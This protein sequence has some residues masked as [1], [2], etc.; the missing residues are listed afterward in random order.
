MKNALEWERVQGKASK[1]I[2]GMERLPFEEKLK[3]LDSSAARGH[4]RG[5]GCDG[6]RRIGKLTS[7]ANVKLL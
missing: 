4:C 7:K 5:E 2:T 6:V 1:N 3:K